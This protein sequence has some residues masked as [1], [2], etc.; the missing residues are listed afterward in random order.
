MVRTSFLSQQI[1]AYAAQNKDDFITEKTKNFVQA[2]RNKERDVAVDFGVLEV[3]YP[4]NEGDI[5]AFENA[6]K[7]KARDENNNVIAKPGDIIR[8]KTQNGGEK[9]YM[10]GV[11]NDWIGY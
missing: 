2:V 4:V 10:W 9:M 3:T 11:A 8:V 6:L 1:I 7:A 5:P